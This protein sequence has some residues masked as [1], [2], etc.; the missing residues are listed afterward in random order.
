MLSVLY[1]HLVFVTRDRQPC[2]DATVAGLLSIYFV[3]VA[4]QEGVQILALGL[5]TTHVHLLI[6]Y[7]P[8][9]SLPRL[10][11]RLKGGSAHLV[12]HHHA[13]ALRWA[14]GYS[15]HSVSPRAVPAAAH[16]VLHQAERHPNQRI[17]GW[18]TGVA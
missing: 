17:E 4:G 15:L 18:P 11:Q 12:T 10:L 14:K 13:R 7:R 16:Y 5:V 2:I 1:A 6:R 8:T 3:Q 9:T